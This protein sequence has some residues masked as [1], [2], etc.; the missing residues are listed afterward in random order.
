MIEVQEIDR[1]ESLA[2]LRPAW[3]A[4]L[5]QTAGA[6]FFRSLPWLE[7]Y[8]KHFGRGQ[9]LRVLVIHDAGQPVGILP[10]VVRPEVTR[11]GRVRVLTYPLHDW[12]TFFGPIGPDAATTLAAGLRHVR[13]TTRDWDLLDLRWIDADGDDLGRTERAMGDAGFRPCGQK[14]DQT[15]LAELPHSWCDYWQTREPKFRKNIDR[16]ESRMA[17]AGKVEL[18]R[19]RGDEDAY[20]APRWDLYDTCIALAERSWQGTGG[21]RTNLCHDE[22]SGYFRDAHAAAAKLGAVDVN[23]LYVN[24]LPAAFA[25]NYQWHGSVYGLR[26]GFD[27]DFANLP[28]DWSCRR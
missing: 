19:F 9:R 10:L 7:C 2:D 20:D 14:W 5:A 15:S 6:S 12:A 11:V 28:P 8:W 1:V 24:G 22:A 16:L 3:D 4:L 18:V 26:K 27:P 25:Y 17:A 21:D 23:L 13:Q